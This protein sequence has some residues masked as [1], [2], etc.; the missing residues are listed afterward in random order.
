MQTDPNWTNFLW[1]PRSRKIE[2]LDFGAS[3]EYSQHFTDMYLKLLK[4]GID[5]NREDC[6]AL[7]IKL[8]Y[9]TGDE[10]QVSHDMYI[11]AWILILR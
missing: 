1:N 9:F 4:A 7:S 2:L 8:G 5:Q 10:S 11:L 3:R 6:I